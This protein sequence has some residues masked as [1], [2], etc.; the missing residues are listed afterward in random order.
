MYKKENGLRMIPLKKEGC[1]I[2]LNIKFKGNGL[3]CDMH[4][5]LYWTMLASFIS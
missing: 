5:L 2:I 1:F 4:Y 3:E